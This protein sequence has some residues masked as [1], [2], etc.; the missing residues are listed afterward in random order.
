MVRFII[1]LN[2]LKIIMIAL[3]KI[4][5]WSTILLRNKAG[6]SY[7][8]IIFRDIAQSSYFKPIIAVKDFLNEQKIKH[9]EG[10]NSYRIRECIFCDKPQSYDILNQNTLNVD[11][12]D[13]KFL[14]SRCQKKA[15]GTNSKPNS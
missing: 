1:K 9:E 4:F 12:A 15:L 3:K 10:P 8:K 7:S 6:W 11:K 14:C 5:G 13:G 2:F